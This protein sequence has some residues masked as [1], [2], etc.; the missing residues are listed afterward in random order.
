[1]GA[2]EVVLDRV[3]LRPERLDL[4]R[5]VRTAVEDRR[6]LLEQ[7]GLAVTLQAP[8]TPVWV[9]GDADRL[10]QV[11]D[12]LLDNELR[13]VDRGGRVDVRLTTAEGEPGASATGA[14]AVL[15]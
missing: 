4:A 1:L 5:L 3:R 2:S 9:H 6:P 13:F 14:C 11:F 12:N 8:D 15:T 10:A 7:A